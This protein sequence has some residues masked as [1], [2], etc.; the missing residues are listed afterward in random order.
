MDPKQIEKELNSYPVVGF[1]FSVTEIDITQDISLLPEIRFSVS[2][3]FLLSQESIEGMVTW[4]YIALS[5]YAS[6]HKAHLEIII[7]EE[8]DITRP[9][10]LTMSA[11]VQMRG[12]PF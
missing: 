10:K 3:K 4:F 8:S 11:N 7:D 1:K 6:K 5:D 12:L 9:G 2:A